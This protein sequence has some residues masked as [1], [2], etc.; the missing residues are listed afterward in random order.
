MTHI[1]QHDGCDWMN[2]QASLS[3]AH[4]GIATPVEGNNATT[5]KQATGFEMLLK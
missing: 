2:V 5:K 4:Q 1:K 3:D